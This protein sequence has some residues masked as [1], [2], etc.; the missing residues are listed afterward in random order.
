[1]RRQ[2]DSGGEAWTGRVDYRAIDAPVIAEIQS[3]RHHTAL[4]DSAADKVRIGQ[5]R[6]DGFIVAEIWDSDVWHRPRRVQDQ[7][8][9]AYSIARRTA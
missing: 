6:A 1:M 4:L 8:R 7:M 9:D 2:I 3:E 5:L